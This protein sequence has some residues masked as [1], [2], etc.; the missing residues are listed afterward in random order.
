VV[1]AAN[2]NPRE[3]EPDEP[4]PDSPISLKI[5]IFPLNIAEDGEQDI[6]EPDGPPIDQVGAFP[7]GLPI[8]QVGAFPDG[9]PNPPS[10][11]IPQDNIF[12]KNDFRLVDCNRDCCAGSRPCES[13]CIIAACKCQ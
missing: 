13:D 5:K 9:N 2:E 6:L 10:A 8:D 3:E 4:E 12:C 7:D 11:A 1:P